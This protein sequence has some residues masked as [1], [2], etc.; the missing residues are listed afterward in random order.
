MSYNVN[1]I[2]FWTSK[3]F[4]NGSPKTSSTVLFRGTTSEIFY[5]YSKD[6]NATYFIDICIAGSWHQVA[7]GGITKDTLTVV[8]LAYYAPMVRVRVTASA[9]PTEVT[10]EAYG[11]PSVYVNIDG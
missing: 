8:T 9:W 5:F 1:Q 2:T 11:Q 3:I 4:E 6:Q 7:T 10:A